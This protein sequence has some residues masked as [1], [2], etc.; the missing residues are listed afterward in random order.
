MEVT[1]WGVIPY[2]EAT[3]RQLERVESLI[4][5]RESPETSASEECL[6]FCSHPPVVTA[7]RGTRAEDVFG[8]KGELVESS[9]G[10]RATYHGPSQIVVYPIL[11]LD[12]NRKSFSARDLHGYLR[13]LEQALVDTLKE[14]Q[15]SAEARTVKVDAGEPSL[16][17]VW[18]GERKVASIGI[19]IKKW[20]T[21]HGLALNIDQDV[22][23]FSGIHPCGLRSNV[24]TSMEEVMG[25]GFPKNQ[26]QAFRSDVEKTLEKFLIKL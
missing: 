19:A 3:R 9:R 7:G 6:I 8:W 26:R 2:Q 23:A 16:T 21:Y 24:M 13:F 10:G 1:R 25:N 15:I 12:Q 18:V 20:V 17:G 22:S 11:N 14:F 5:S 4:S